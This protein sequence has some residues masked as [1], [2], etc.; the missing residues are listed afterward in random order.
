MKSKH[1][2]SLLFSTIFSVALL[3]FLTFL[4]LHVNFPKEKPRLA[5]TTETIVSKNK[6]A[7]QYTA[8]GDSLTEGV[9]D[10]TS[11]G[12][13]VPL[14]ADGLQEEFELTR[15]E[16][17]NYGV[18]GERSDQL[19]KR[20]N[21]EEAI[22]ANLATSDIIT[23]TVGG[24]DLMKVIQDNIFGLSVKT[25]AKPLKKYQQR[26]TELLTEIRTLNPEAPIY[27]LGIYN[28]FY[29]NFPEITDMQTIVNNWNDGTK[30]IVDEQENMYFILIN[31]LL[32]KGLKQPAIGDPEATTESTEVKNDLNI[33]K[34][35]VLYDKDKFHP[36]NIGYQ[37]MARA[38]KEEITRTQKQWL[39]EEEPK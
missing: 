17:E 21:K 35:N 29:V 1:F 12:G 26:V 16:I 18:A 10:D 13:F 33:V 2:L 6:Q 19:I 8:F 32:F 7:I 36:N 31:D 22:R 34:N 37:L 14:V 39:P 9:G 25:F 15:V 24:N 3:A 4:I 28:P 30:E 20:L 38:V 27:V 23:V 5:A 11:R